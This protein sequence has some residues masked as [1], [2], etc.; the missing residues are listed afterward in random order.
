MENSYTGG[1]SVTGEFY[2]VEFAAVLHKLKP[3]KAPDQLFS[4]LIL[5]AG[6]TIK[7]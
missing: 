2:I 3:G 7:S 4:K 5:H 1:S 6:P